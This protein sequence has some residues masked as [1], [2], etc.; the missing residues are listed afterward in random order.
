MPYGVDKKLGGDSHENDSWMEKCVDKVMATG[1]S[2]ESAIKIC[3]FTMKKS[4]ML[5]GMEKK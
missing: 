3:K 4:K 2:K 1:K 5:E